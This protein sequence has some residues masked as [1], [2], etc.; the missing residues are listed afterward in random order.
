MKFQESLEKKLDEE[1]LLALEDKDFDKEMN[2]AL[3]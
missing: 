2:T 1:I 3:N